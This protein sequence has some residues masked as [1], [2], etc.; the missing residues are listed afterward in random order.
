VQRRHLDAGRYFVRRYATRAGKN[1]RSIDKKTLELFQFYDWPGNIQDL[2]NIIERSVMLSSGDVFSVDES[3][4]KESFQP[5]SRVQEPQRFKGEP[6]GQREMIEA[7][8][9]ESRGRVSG[10][11]GAATKLRIPPSTLEH[12]IKALNIRKGEFEFG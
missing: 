4:P 6:R 1:I 12:K 7:M 8:L 9:A 3:W 11:S 2:Q 10:R 5:A